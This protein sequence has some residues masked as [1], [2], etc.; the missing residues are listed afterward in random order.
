MWKLKI[1]IFLI[2][3]TVEMTNIW[4]DGDKAK[5]HNSCPRKRKTSNINVTIEC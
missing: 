2:T 4:T 1:L 3:L 5:G